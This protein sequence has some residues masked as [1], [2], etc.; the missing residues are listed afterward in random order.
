MS[1]IHNNVYYIHL[2]LYDAE[3]FC[4]GTGSYYLWSI[5]VYTLNK[6]TVRKQEK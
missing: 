4:E 2:R 6:V 5:N 1:P 3:H